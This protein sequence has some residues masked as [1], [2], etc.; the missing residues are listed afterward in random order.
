MRP[1]LPGEIKPVDMVPS[2]AQ[3]EVLASLK[4]GPRDI[5]PD[6][7]NCYGYLWVTGNYRWFEDGDH[8]K[9]RNGDC[10]EAK[11]ALQRPGDPVAEWRTRSKWTGYRLTPQ[12]VEAMARYERTFMI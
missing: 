10:L 9:E 11:A 6:H 3:Y 12:G 4:G 8:K 2:A 7:T 5:F 1:L